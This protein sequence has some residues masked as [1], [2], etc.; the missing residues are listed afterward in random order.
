[1]NWLG[2][3]NDKGPSQ[4][5]LRVSWGF[6]SQEREKPLALD[7]I[8]GLPSTSEL[9]LGS[10]SLPTNRVITKGA[11]KEA[12]PKDIK[13]TPEPFLGASCYMKENVI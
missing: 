7:F 5:I 2:L 1:M 12:R 13:G 6:C 4:F 8:Q 3:K 11:E 9:G 10:T